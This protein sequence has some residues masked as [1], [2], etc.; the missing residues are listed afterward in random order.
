MIE[1]SAIAEGSPGM[2]LLE[3]EHEHC[4]LPY[5]EWDN[6]LQ[7]CGGIWVVDLLKM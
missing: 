4:L 6:E 7:S 2:I 1:L 3:V 5:L